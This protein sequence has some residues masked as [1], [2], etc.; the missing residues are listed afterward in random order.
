[1]RGRGKREAD[2]VAVVE[3]LV[4]GGSVAAGPL[5]E[6][7]KQGEGGVVR[8]LSVECLCRDSIATGTKSPSLSLRASENN[9]YRVAERIL[10]QRESDEMSRLCGCGA[11]E[12]G[13]WR[14]L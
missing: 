2:D 5:S 8:G 12:D 14:E 9:H 1:M 11:G 6:A 13:S 10:Q 7:M 3:A 4:R